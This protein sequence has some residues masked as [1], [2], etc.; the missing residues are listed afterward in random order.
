[1]TADDPLGGLVAAAANPVMRLHRGL[2]QNSRGSVFS[3]SRVQLTPLALAQVPGPAVAAPDELDDPPALLSIELVQMLPGQEEQLA[4]HDQ[5]GGGNLRS[6]L[7]AQACWARLAA[8]AACPISST[9]NAPRRVTRGAPG[10]PSRPGNK[11][12]GPDAAGRRA[13]S[14]AAA[15]RGGAARTARTARRTRLSL[16]HGSAGRPSRP[17]RRFTPPTASSP[18]STTSSGNAPGSRHGADGPRRLLDGHGHELRP[19]SRP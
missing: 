9:E 15:A 10:P 14:A 5:P 2:G 16:V 4:E 3:S 8:K 6:K 19:R 18:I 11:R 17:P 7:Y 12:A 13:R 1:M